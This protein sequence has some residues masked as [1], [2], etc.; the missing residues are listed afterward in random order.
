MHRNSGFSTPLT[1][2]LLALSLA[3]FVLGCQKPPA[4]SPEVK[5]PEVFISSPVSKE[6]TDFED[7]TGR[8]G[9]VK[10]VEVRARVSGYLDDVQFTDGAD[11]E[12]GTPLFRIDPRPFAAELAK[13]EATEKQMKSRQERLKRQEERLVRLVEQKVSTA[14]DLELIRFHGRS[15]QPRPGG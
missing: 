9:P 12:K 2:T 10:I 1:T 6:V 4:K 14:E 13:A 8:L 11:V 7:A 15:R 5:L 3:G